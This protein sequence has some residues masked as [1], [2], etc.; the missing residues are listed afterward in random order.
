M[1][2][3]LARRRQGIS[4]AQAL[5]LAGLGLALFTAGLTWLFGGWALVGVGAALMTLALLLIPVR[6]RRG[7][8]VDDAAASPR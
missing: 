6:E 1:S 8:P 4:V 7:E 3:A 2:E 5:G